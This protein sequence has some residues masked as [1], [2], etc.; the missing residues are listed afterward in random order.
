MEYPGDQ[1]VPTWIRNV[2]N[3]YKLDGILLG[4]RETIVLLLPGARDYDPGQQRGG[5]VAVSP[6]PEEWSEILRR[7]DDPV[8]YGEDKAWHRKARYVISGFTQQRTWVRDGYRCMFCGRKM[9]D[10]Q[11]SV[12]HFIPLELG[13]ANDTSNYISACRR[14]NR[15][16]GSAYPMIFCEMNGYDYDGLVRYLAGEIDAS[17]ID[18]ARRW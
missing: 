16:K 6:S 1:S 5:Y 11:L 17:Q 13:G 4:G 2:G 9:G 18:H 10:V 15:D 3:L 7:S 14:C 8:F 12:D